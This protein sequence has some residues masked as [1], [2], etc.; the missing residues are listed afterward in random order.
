MA[1]P[2]ALRRPVSLLV[3]VAMLA[4]VVL[5]G[6][7]LLAS[8]KQKQLTAYFPRTIGI[9]KGS[10]VRVLGVAVGEVTRIQPQGTRVRVDMTYDASRK[11]PANVGA[12][13]VPP[14]IVSDRYLQLTPVYTGGPVLGNHAAIQENRT[15]IPVELDAIFG[16]LNDLNTS[17]GPNG[18]NNSGALSRLV[19][20]GAANLRGNG[21][22]FNS[23]LHGFSEAINALADSKDALFGTITQLQKFTTT[24]AQDDGGVRRVNAE[25]TSV[26]A[27]LAGERQDLGAALA[28]LA[29]ALGQ[30]QGFVSANRTELTHDVHALTTI[31]SGLV[32][33]QQAIKEVIDEAPLGLHNLSL[34]FSTTDG[35]CDAKGQ[36]CK[37]LLR[38][39]ANIDPNSLVCALLEG[40]ARTNGL[41]SQV[42]GTLPDCSSLS[43]GAPAAPSGASPG[44]PAGS[45]VPTPAIPDVPPAPLQQP[46]A[47]PVSAPPVPTLSPLPLPTGG[48]LGGNG[49]LLG[50]GGSS[51]DGS[52]GLLGGGLGAELTAA[53]R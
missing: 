41:T 42:A 4:A 27:Q 14:S 32:G 16:S 37:G 12:A 46:A 51:G 38:T 8:G 5:V 9:Y 44:S 3:A 11:L 13:L 52:G 17:L 10:S 1:L 2:S 28:N 29:Q 23:T 15:E 20:V 47:P 40:Y 39:R 26:A 49:S 18:A 22:E 19:D 45:I 33:E 53:L 34:A 21:A 30:V 6:V 25:L 43:A 35:D 48:L 31:S 24:L 36:N 7:H 50:G